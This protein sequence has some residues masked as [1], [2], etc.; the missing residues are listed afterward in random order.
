MQPD[1]IRRIKS[2]QK[3]YLELVAIMDRARKGVN[4]NFVLM[5]DNTLK[6]KDRLCIPHVG[7]LRLE[8][9]HNSRFTIH[10]GGTKMYSDM[11]QLY[12]W[13]GFKRDIAKFIAQC[14]VFQEVKAEHQ[15]LGGKL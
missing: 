3:D 14:L 6:F 7:E 4:S 1:F 9:F 5:D 2:S 8:E 11:K 12:W 10:P 15:R 13:P